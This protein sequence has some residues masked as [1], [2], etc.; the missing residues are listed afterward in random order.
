LRESSNLYK[1]ITASTP[2]IGDLDL[3][4]IPEIVA[5]RAQT[6]MVSFVFREVADNNKQVAFKWN[7][8]AQRYQR[9]WVS[10]QTNIAMNTQR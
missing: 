9:F 8:T 3:D 4:G 7:T 1:T 10:S 6:G 5:Q 2:A